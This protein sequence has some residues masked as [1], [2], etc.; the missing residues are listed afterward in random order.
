VKKKK[1]VDHLLQIITSH[2]VSECCVK[3]GVKE[4]AMGDL[5]G[6]REN[7]DSNDSIHQRLHH[8]PYR[9]MI[10]MIRY[11]AHGQALK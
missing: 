11:K 3:K 2:L 7:I 6:I 5:N 4:I 9:I 1:Q 10:K 8:W